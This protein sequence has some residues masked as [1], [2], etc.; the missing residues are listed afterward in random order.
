MQLQYNLELLLLTLAGGSLPL[1]IK[2]ADEQR[3][4]YLLAFSGSFL[5][6]ITFLHLLPEAFT[7]VPGKAGYLLLTG[8]FVQLIIQRFTHGAEHGHTHLLDHR[9]VPLLSILLG[10]CLHAFLEG[11]PLGFSYH[12]GSTIPSLYLAVTVHKVPEAMLVT[13]LVLHTRGRRSAITM[14]ML[15][16]FITPLAGTLASYL[17][18]HY[19]V[20]HRTIMLLV[21]VVAGSFIHISTTIFFE[22]GTKQHAMNS[23]KIIAILSGVVLGLLTLMFE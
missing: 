21:P 17:G 12:T 22:S 9:H 1:W 18:R 10:L 6:S 14:L 7:D 8:F 11:L 13:S 20:V 16:S 23:R 2:R 15:F 5:L 3:S 19:E 4:N